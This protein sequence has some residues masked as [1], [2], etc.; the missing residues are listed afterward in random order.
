MYL[1]PDTANN[2]PH[3]MPVSACQG[4]ES[5]NRSK[6]KPF[7]DINLGCGTSVVSNAYRAVW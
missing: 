3:A 7:S 1:V 4:V 5:H 6:A 2:C